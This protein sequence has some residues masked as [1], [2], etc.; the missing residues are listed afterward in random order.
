MEFKGTKGE[1]T[2]KHRQGAGFEVLNENNNIVCA[3][4]WYQLPSDIMNLGIEEANSK[5]AAA[6]P[7]MLKALI[8]AKEMLMNQVDMRSEIIENAIKKALE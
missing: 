4:G 2:S 1:W 8:H 6:A 3:M 5:L 7:D